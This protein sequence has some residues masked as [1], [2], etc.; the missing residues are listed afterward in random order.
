MTADLPDLL[1]Q[2]PVPMWRRA[3]VLGGLALGLL[4]LLLWSFSQGRPVALPEAAE[5]R[6]PCVSYAP[7]RRPGHSPFDP[8]LNVEPAMIEADLRLLSQVTGCIRTYGLDHGLDAVPAIARKL[9]LRVVLGAWIDG[10]AVTNQAQLD[11]ALGL[12]RDYADVIDLLVVGNEVLLRGE[13]PAAE[14]ANLLARARRESAVPVAYADVWEFWLR[15]A[16]ALRPH[17][18]VVAAHVLPYWEDEPVA[19]EQA[20]LHVAAVNAKIRAFFAPLP[21]FIA[22][23]GWPAAGRQRGAAVPGRLEQARFIRE[24][25]ARQDA[26][27]HYNLIEGFDQPWKRQLEGAMGGY[28]GLFAADGT[29]RVSLHGSVVADPVWW[30]LPLGAL[31]GGAAGLVWGLGGGMLRGPKPASARKPHGRVA[32]AA[33]MLAGAG[34]VPL[35]V[36][37]GQMLLQWSRNPLDWTFGAGVALSAGLCA[38]LAAGRLASLFDGWIPAGNRPGLIA[39][40]SSKNQ[41]SQRWLVIT[42]AVLLGF[43]TLMAVGLVFDARYRPLVWPLLIAPAVLMCALAVMGDR[44]GAAAKLERGLAC[45]IAIAAG[46]VVWQEG[47]ANGQ[48]LGLAF[49]WLGLAFAVGWPQRTTPGSGPSLARL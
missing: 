19:I 38:L 25:L 10:N 46:L 45:L 8:A 3:L 32:I 43:V 20:V 33:L 35:G 40:Q 13:L 1:S 15:H 27:L 41:R 42:V 16:D 48:A 49:T 5:L 6:L 36:L 11:K 47:L 39:V 30:Y 17:V 21:V 44:L 37:Q 7:F 34:L 12:S 2:K 28:W 14:L 18:D 31:V 26:T 4:I 22:E 9:G 29:Q 23:T 24:L